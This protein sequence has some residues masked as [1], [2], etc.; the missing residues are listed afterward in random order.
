MASSVARAFTLR[1]D[2]A[3]KRLLTLCGV[4]ALVA[5][6]LVSARSAPPAAASAD[7]GGTATTYSEISWGRNDDVQAFIHANVDTLDN[8][9]TLYIQI[10][11]W[12]DSRTNTNTV[13]KAVREAVDRGVDLN[14][15]TEAKAYNSTSTAAQRNILDALYDLS[16]DL[17]CSIAGTPSCANTN[18]T[19]NLRA[20]WYGCEFDANGSTSNGGVMHDKLVFATAGDG[21]WAISSSG[22]WKNLTSNKYEVA[23]RF[24]TG[25]YDDIHDFLYDR[26]QCMW[27]TAYGTGGAGVITG[28]DHANGY[29]YGA[30]STANERVQEDCPH[31][32]N[33]FTGYQSKYQGQAGAIDFGGSYANHQNGSTSWATI[34]RKPRPI[35]CDN[36]YVMSGVMDHSTQI[37][38]SIRAMREKED[39]NCDVDL[40]FGDPGDFDEI[41]SQAKAPAFSD[42]EPFEAELQWRVLGDG[43]AGQGRPHAKM[44]AI[45]ADFYDDG[46]H[47]EEQARVWIGSANFTDN[48]YEKNDEIVFRLKDETSPYVIYDE[49]VA[50][51]N[52]VEADEGSS[53]G[54][55]G[56][57]CSTLKHFE[58][59]DGTGDRFQIG[60]DWYENRTGTGAGRTNTLANVRC[61]G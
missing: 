16:G 24:D 2:P 39:D 5:T 40:I 13:Y 59:E 1:R 38:D 22:N 27:W 46:T 23:L 51:F 35:N 8:G 18:G 60:T 58:G 11:E 31:H 21:N 12:H 20:C 52:Y 44:V 15:L 57:G 17:G 48:I 36:I 7:S 33:G 49:A 34:L 26:W 37:E 45:R 14:V 4:C 6:L 28:A 30:S 41:L 3:M 32:A 29:V 10:Y 43:L 47:W 61:P 55:D 19:V 56:Y 50:F 53:T 54:S 25:Y 9:D 42:E